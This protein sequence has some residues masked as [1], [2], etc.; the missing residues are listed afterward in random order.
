MPS[1]LQS[2]LKQRKPFTS[3]EVEAYLNLA[4]TTDRLG[5]AVEALLGEHDLTQ[6]QY[7]VLR[8]LRGAQPDGLP[9]GEV[10]ARLVTHDPDVTRLLDRLERR[11]LVARS[12]SATDRRQ[13]WTRITPA[14]LA[15][16]S[17]MKDDET[18]GALHRRQFAA[19]SRDEL[20]TLIH[21][22]EAIRPPDA[23]RS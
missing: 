9:C 15:L 5:R 6:V 14:G 3:L 19:L 17:S 7:N 4:R 23:P 1:R 21:L 12:R 11:G 2:E 13:V 8:I 16:L 22:L 18:L 20:A 10:A